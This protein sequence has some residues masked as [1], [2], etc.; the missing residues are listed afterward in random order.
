MNLRAGQ[1]KE[2]FSLDEII[3]AAWIDFVERSMISTAFAPKED[4]GV[5]LYGQCWDGRIEYAMGAFNGQPRNVAENNDDKDVAGRLV[6]APWVTSDYALLKGLYLGV[7]ATHGEQD[8]NLAGDSYRTASTLPFFT[9]AEGIR[10]DGKFDRLGADIEWLIG[11][12]SLRAE[13]MKVDQEY[14]HGV[15]TRA[16]MNADGWYVSGTYLLT[17]EDKPRDRNINDLN[18]KNGTLGAWEVEARYEEFNADSDLLER[19]L[20]TGTDQ[21]RAL[22]AG[23]NWYPNSNVRVM[24]NAVHVKFDDTLLVDGHAVDDEDLALLR[25]QYSL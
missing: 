5:G 23:L 12:A 11:P 24:A 22:T 6:I 21:A 2:P 15:E 16:D 19:S 25:L 18:L 17:G 9:Y 20:A 3:S 14:V 1:I 8:E 4:V 10:N 7:C 13:W